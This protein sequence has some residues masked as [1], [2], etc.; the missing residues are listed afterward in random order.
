MDDSLNYFPSTVIGKR[1]QHKVHHPVFD[2][3]AFLKA[4]YRF[5]V[6]GPSASET[7]NPYMLIHNNKKSYWNDVEQVLFDLE[8]NNDFLAQYVYANPKCH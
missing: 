4:T 2:R 7:N 3:N 1:S 8:D 6:S 5:V